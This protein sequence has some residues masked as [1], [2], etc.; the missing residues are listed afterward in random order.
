MFCLGDFT[1]FISCIV[2]LIVQSS[3][4]S[5]IIGGNEVQPH[6][7]PF[8]AL[9][10]SKQ[11]VCGGILINPTWVLTAAHCADIKRV[12]LGVHSI[13]QKEKD[14]RQMR[15]VTRSVPHPC[16]DAADK[17]NDLMLLKLDKP[18]KETKT[19]KCLRMGN[20]VKEPAAGT[21]CLVAGWGTTNNAV[22]QM[23]DVLMSVNVTVIDR[24]KCNSPE[25]Y[26]LKPVITSGMICAGSDG[27]NRADTCAGDSGGPLLCNGV[28][29]GVT[30]FGG[31]CGLLKRPGVYTFLTEKQLIWIKKTTKKSEI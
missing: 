27:N 22:K 4:G 8:M 15:K 25:Y 28:L 21:S 14:S 19:V 31:K 2:L 16:Y 23:S 6:S 24:V 26:N 18:V 5:E 13:K 10:E 17:V 12:V 1:G 29:A 11:P 30:S 7:L 3:Y 20:T 9:L